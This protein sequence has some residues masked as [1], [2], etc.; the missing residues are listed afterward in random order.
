MSTVE[1]PPAVTI[2][3]PTYQEV[4]NIPLL[5]ER[6]DKVRRENHLEIELLLM[7]DNSCDGS[8]ELVEGMNLA[9]VKLITRTGNRGLSNSVL[10]GLR[11]ARHDTVLVMDADLSHPPEKIPEMLDRLKKGADFV[12]GSRFVKG[13]S[14][15][16]DWGLF[17]WLNSRVAA[18]FARPL[19]RV[20]D[21]LSGFF[22]MRKSTFLEAETLNPVG[23]KIGLELLVKSHCSRTEEVP[24]YFADR[25]HGKSK[26]SVME[27]LRYLQHILRL[28]SYESRR[29]FRRNDYW[30]VAM[31]ACVFLSTLAA[32]TFLPRQ[33][34]W[35]DET[36]QLSGLTLGP[37]GLTRWL[38]G[39]GHPFLVP[40]DRMPPISYWAQWVWIQLFGS[41][42]ETLR[43]FG[44]VCVSLSVAVTF[45][46][47]RRGFGTFVA[48]LTALLLG[49]APNVVTNAVEIRAYPIFLLE[50]S[51]GFYFLVRYASD[52][53]ERSGYWLTW[54]VVTCIAGMFTHLF[55]VVFAGALIIGA[56]VISLQRFREIR[57]PAF[58]TAVLAVC[59]LGLI[60][61][62]RAAFAISGNGPQEQ[63]VAGKST[64][65]AI[66]RLVY[67]LCAH[68]VTSLNA[69]AVVAAIVGLLLLLLSLVARLKAVNLKERSLAVALASGLTVVALA[70][71][72]ANGFEP[73]APHYNI[74]I[75]PGLY[76]LLAAG[77][78]STSRPARQLA[79]VGALL[80]IGGNVYSDTQLAIHGRN[81]AHGTEPQLETLVR[82]FGGPGKVAIVY[83]NGSDLPPGYNAWPFDYYSLAY[84][85]GKDLP[86]YVALAAPIG[87]V[88]QCNLPS[89]ARSTTDL[90]RP[91]IFVVRAQQ[92]YTREI[93]SQI[94]NGMKPFGPGPFCLLM[95][96]SGLWK[97]IGQEYF[98]SLQASQV[99]IFQT[100]SSKPRLFNSIASNA[101]P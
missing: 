49:L 81:F 55:G 74:W 83:E 70:G 12:I 21:P 62:I 31:L 18:L 35:I 90:A 8:A 86:Q 92:E 3:V 93:V 58:A 50:A 79:L 89:P 46:A 51:F 24:I 56:F 19:A 6:I 47:A 80:L 4:E 38:A 65:S 77:V 27:Q 28:Y 34:I 57:R 66:A 29:W 13:G 69:G 101:S 17:R 99:D 82:H 16:D 48:V 68:P 10:D 87:S 95:E 43:A 98:L 14:T 96:K 39:Q 2:V 42:V 9:W 11:L 36:T 41:G 44:V 23:Y 61:F 71:L 85:Y 78:A 52:H 59:G 73:L 22:M 40:P 37:L 100:T 76:L 15:D 1:I 7:D 26:L 97:H 53:A 33:S 75:L 45:A 25:R 32:V 30:P 60:P 20:K 72:V 67:Q 63:S 64:L 91:Y 84:I 5:V 88:K 94:S 54:M